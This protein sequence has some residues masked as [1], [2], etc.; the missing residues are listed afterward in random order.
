MS[1]DAYLNLDTPMHL[2]LWAIMAS[3]HKAALH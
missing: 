3:A 2:D 1:I